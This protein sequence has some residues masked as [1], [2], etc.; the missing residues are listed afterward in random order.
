MIFI[1]A[2][3]VYCHLLTFNGWKMEDLLSDP[4]EDNVSDVDPEELQ[5]MLEVK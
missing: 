5:K 2:N 4:S 3:V 1:P